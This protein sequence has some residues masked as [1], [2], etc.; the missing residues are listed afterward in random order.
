MTNAAHARA[1]LV[2]PFG[3]FSA[4][5]YRFRPD[6]SAV[7]QISANGCNT[8]GCEI[9]PDGEYIYTTA[10]CG[11]P[12]LHVVLPEKYL[13]RGS[14]GGH[15]AWQNII[16]ENKIY[17]AFDEK[18]SPYVQIDWVG[19]W[20]AAAGATIYDGGA[21]PAKWT[22]DERYS[23]FMGEA[24]RQLFHHV[25]MSPP[26]LRT[27]PLLVPSQRPPFGPTAMARTVFERPPI[28]RS[29]K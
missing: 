8:W 15:P 9:A 21:W 26:F 19:A 11:T 24:T 4:G 14:V 7:E 3:D 18:R 10:T 13:A 12:I 17:P 28:S 23:F 27:T 2:L 25:L 20:T 16:E 6:G 1:G 5:M 29:R 22:P